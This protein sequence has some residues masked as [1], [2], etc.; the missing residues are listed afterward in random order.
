MTTALPDVFLPYQQE[1]MAEVDRNVLIAVE[2]SRRTGYTWTVAAIAVMEAMKARSIGGQDV[3]Y[4]AYEKDIAREFIDY[5]AM[6]AKAFQHAASEVEELV[7]PDPDRPNRTI[8]TFRISFASGFDIVAVPNAARRLRGRQ[9]LVILDEAAFMDDL[10]AVLTAAYRFSEQ[11]AITELR[12][13][14]RTAYD[15]INEAERERKRHRGKKDDR[16]LDSTP[17]PF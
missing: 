7:L 5:C 15:R 16:K 12:V 17:V 9:G 13:A 11:G 1:L 4:M 6:W 10:D 3:I 2:K 8:W 14:G